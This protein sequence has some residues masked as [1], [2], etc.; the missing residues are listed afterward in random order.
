MRPKLKKPFGQKKSGVIARDATV[1][2]WLVNLFTEHDLSVLLQCFIGGGWHRTKRNRLLPNLSLSREGLELMADTTDPA[3][4]IA[5]PILNLTAQIV[6][7]YVE[8]NVVVSEGLPSLI[9][10][11]YAA[12]AAS[13]E[14]AEKPVPAVALKRSV[15]PDYIVCLEDGKKMKLLK[16]YLAT[17]YNMTPET[18]R[19]RWGLPNDYPMV[20]PSYAAR[21]AALAREIG[22]GRKVGPRA[23]AAALEDNADEIK[24]TRVPERRRGRKPLSR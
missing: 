17:Q 3:S 19:T 5:G 8:H 24:I 1:V 2:T 18:Y 23:L 6:A 11:T 14:T 7:A 9:R 15:F 12:L 4:N 10:A 20:A 22:L 13:T 16:R 21:R